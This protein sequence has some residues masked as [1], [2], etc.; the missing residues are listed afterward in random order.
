MNELKYKHNVMGILK[1]LGWAVQAHEDM[2]SKFVPDLS[3]GSGGADGWL[4]LKYLNDP[5][6]S[7][8]AIHHYTRGQEDWLIRRGKIG[9]GHCYL[10]MG[11]Q[12]HNYLWRWDA[13]GEVRSLPWPEAVERS[14]HADGIGA[15]LRQ[16]TAV[17]Q[18]RG[19]Y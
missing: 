3:F 4:E 2:I 1:G 12:H 14:M 7:L 6:K 13:L 11:T 5:P 17:V 19:S 10:L 15:L 8:G 16:L 18:Q 9:S